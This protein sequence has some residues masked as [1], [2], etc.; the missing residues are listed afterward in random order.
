VQHGGMQPRTLRVS[1][2]HP[3]T[4]SNARNPASGKVR[5][6]DV[7]SLVRAVSCQPPAGF[8]KKAPQHGNSAQFEGDLSFENRRCVC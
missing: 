1:W 5:A 7:V 4:A 6:A 8:G 2:A 3:V